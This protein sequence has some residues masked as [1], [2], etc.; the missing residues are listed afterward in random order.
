MTKLIYAAS[1]AALLSIAGTLPS[2]AQSSTSGTSGA[3]S[4]SITCRDFSTMDRETAR[5]VAFYVRGFE[6][7]S[8]SSMASS[9]GTSGTEGAAG[10]TGTTG[11]TSGDTTGST[12]SAGGSGSSTSTEASGSTSGSASGGA[13]SAMM[14]QLPGFSNVDV[15]KLM[16]A[17][18]SSPDKKLSEVMGSSSSTQ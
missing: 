10:T 8:G 16:T 15:D 4:P 18:Q 3:M 6:A 2:L 5:N 1:A 12:S 17:C 9:S 14:A 13:S 11:T 7:A